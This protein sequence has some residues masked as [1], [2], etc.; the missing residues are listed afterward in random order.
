MSH[1]FRVEKSIE[2]NGHQRSN[3]SGTMRRWTVSRDKVNTSSLRFVFSQSSKHDHES[4]VVH[5]SSIQPQHRGTTQ[6]EKK[7]LRDAQL[8]DQVIREASRLQDLLPRSESELVDIVLKS[9]N[10]SFSEVKLNIKTRFDENV[11]EDVESVIR[12]ATSSRSSEKKRD[13]HEILEHLNA[14]LFR[15]TFSKRQ[16]KTLS[17]WQTRTLE[18]DASRNA[19]RYFESGK[20]AD[21]NDRYVGALG[22]RFRGLFDLSCRKSSA[23][24][25]GKKD[26]YEILLDA[27]GWKWDLKSNDDVELAA[28]Q[29][30]HEEPRVHRMILRAKTKTQRDRWL[31]ALEVCHTRARDSK[32]KTSVVLSSH[33][34]SDSDVDIA[35]LTTH[36]G[37]SIK[38]LC[39]E[40]S[41]LELDCAFWASFVESAIVCV[42]L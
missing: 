25:H 42:N 33:P 3:T 22:G 9:A 24:L 6:Q 35:R 13:A 11:W 41:D 20:D 8:R 37:E 1:F 31:H 4:C 17:F 38:H 30:R 14:A 21:R 28:M 7:D 39:N 36:S 23:K 18:L 40:I 32:H 12:F 15:T 2:F 29:A 34:S 5:F 19:I 27:V 10:M 16:D 26:A